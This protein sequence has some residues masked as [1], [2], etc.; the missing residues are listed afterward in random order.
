MGRPDTLIVRDLESARELELESGAR[1]TRTAA[2]QASRWLVR[3]GSLPGELVFRVRRKL[4]RLAHFLRP[5]LLE[6]ERLRFLDQRIF[7]APHSRTRTLAVAAV[8]AIGGSERLKARNLDYMRGYAKRRETRLISYPKLIHVE[9]STYCNLRC[10]MCSITRPSRNRE[11]AY[12][13]LDIVRRLRPV[14]PFIRDC[15]L[16]GGGEPFLHPEIEPILEEFRRYG[17]R[18]NTVT[19]A[20]LIDDRI[21]RLIGETFS[22]LTVSVDGATRETYEHIRVGSSFD[23]MRRGIELVNRYRNPDFKLIIGVVIMKSNLHELPDLVRFAKEH[24]AQELQAAWM[25][26]FPD[27]PWT[28][29]ENPILAPER[30]NAWLAKTRAAGKALGLSIRIPDDLPIAKPGANVNPKHESCYNDLHGTTRVEGH[31]RLMYDRAMVLVDGRVKPC[32][33]S[34]TVDDMGSLVDQSFDEIWNGPAYQRL[35]RTFASGTLPETC[36][37][38]NFI[39]SGQLGD[40]KLVFDERFEV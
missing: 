9:L 14:L 16:H 2:T 31:C 5:G 12:M 18:L 25:V 13:P 20:T 33:Q 37:S 1:R 3:I 32:G 24:G 34:E 23:K 35:R 36:R 39:R 21:A 17:V 38:C 19:N 40:A 29:G 6:R 7:K 27:L 4:R 30:A 22:T 11:L 8:R 15:K 26:P 10:R 28:H